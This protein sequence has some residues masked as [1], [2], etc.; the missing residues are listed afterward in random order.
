MS[1]RTEYIAD[2]FPP[3]LQRPYSTN[4]LLLCHSF[5][6]CF[7]SSSYQQKFGLRE[8]F[9]LRSIYAFG[10]I[11]GLLSTYTNRSL[12]IEEFKNQIQVI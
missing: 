3:L 9:I 5:L 11:L 12:T 7:F 1:L 8:I 2:N 4:Q 6:F 10:F